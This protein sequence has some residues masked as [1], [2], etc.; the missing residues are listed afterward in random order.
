MCFS[1][2]I[3]PNKIRVGL[4]P[5]GGFTGS[6][7]LPS[8]LTH[9][10]DTNMTQDAIKSAIDT[11][12]LV[13]FPRSLAVA[14]GTAVPLVQ[15]EGRDG[16]PKLMLLVTYGTSENQFQTKVAAAVGVHSGIDAIAVGVGPNYDLGELT[17]IAKDAS[18]IVTTSLFT[19]LSSLDL[20]TP[21]CSGRFPSLP[22]L[23]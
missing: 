7:P 21:L 23:F 6:V 14:M 18:S 13:P 8:P 12:A 1:L 4:V 3:G 9:L 11:L 20:S 17:V 15:N 19:T 22:Y 10:N 2:D 5:S 16:V